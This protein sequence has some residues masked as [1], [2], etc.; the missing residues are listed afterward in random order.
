MIEIM[1]KTKVIS[2]KQESLSNREVARRTGLKRETVAK[3]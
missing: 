3:Y 2:L 1:Q